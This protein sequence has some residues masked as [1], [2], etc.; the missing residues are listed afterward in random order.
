M[1]I[2][3][4]IGNSEWCD[5]SA[6]LKSG[7]GRFGWS[8]EETADLYSLRDRIASK[9]WDDLS[10][11]EQNCYQGFLLDLKAG[12]Y[13]AYINIPEWGKCTVAKVNGPYTWRYEDEDFN[14]RFPVDPDSIRVFDR[15]DKHVHP[16][17]SARLKLQRRWW[18]IYLEKEFSD[19]LASLDIGD[20]AKARTPEDNLRFLSDEIQPLLVKITEHIHHT[21]P[22][23]DF[24]KLMAEVFKEVPGVVDVELKG[25]AGDHG[26]DLLVTYKHGLPIP[27]LEQDQVLVVQVKSYE[28]EHWD[29]Q[30]AKDIR[31]AFEHYP[32]AEMGLIVSTASSSTEQLDSALQKLVEESKK[33]VALLVGSDVSAFILRYGAKLLG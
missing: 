22:N 32:Q 1:N 21:H 3:A 27:G 8:Y 9:G 20:I 11:N 30:A 18:R 4:L 10:K 16:A 2:Y 7:E 5:I 12:D 25:G 13:V 17:L 31:R 15:N 14:H 24:E 23:Y 19:L 33:P 28:G 26:A 6:S 29:T